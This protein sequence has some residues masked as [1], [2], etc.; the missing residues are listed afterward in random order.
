MAEPASPSVSNEKVALAS[1][2][3]SQ[4]SAAGHTCVEYLTEQT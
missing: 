1:S 3:S 2:I 4:K